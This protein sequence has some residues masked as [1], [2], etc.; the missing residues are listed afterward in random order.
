MRRRSSR[1][2]EPG[3]RRHDLK[4]TTKFPTRVS[5]LFLS[6]EIAKQADLTNEQGRAAVNA[7]WDILWEEMLRGRRIPIGAGGH[8]SLVVRRQR[9][10]AGNPEAGYVFPQVVL[11]GRVSAAG[12]RA[13]RDMHFDDW[14]RET[15]ADGELCIDNRLFDP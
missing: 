10:P 1:G 4:N 3:Q 9:I 6:R 15:E 2:N 14:V 8:V 5:K 12:K 11:I 7:L 13:W